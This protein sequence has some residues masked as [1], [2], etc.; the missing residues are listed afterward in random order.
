MGEQSSASLAFF[1]D[2]I[3]EA[4]F[5]EI[6]S[7]VFS[8]RDGNNAETDQLLM[9]GESSSHGSGFGES[10]SLAMSYAVARR[11]LPHPLRLP[12]PPSLADRA[13]PRAIWLTFFSLACD[14]NACLP[15]AQ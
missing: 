9:G 1:N 10:G 15:V 13:K 14:C 11:C 7:E 6:A 3:D 8:F 12:R 2:V 5:S 4:G